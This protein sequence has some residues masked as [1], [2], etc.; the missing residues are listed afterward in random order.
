[1]V[2]DVT[3]ISKQPGAG[4]EFH[5]CQDFGSFASA[6]DQLSFEGP[7]SVDGT[8]MNIGEGIYEVQAKVDCTWVS[9]CARCLE[10]VSVPMAVELKERFVRGADE[11][12]DAYPF[13]ND[14][15]VL[16]AFV[17]DGILLDLPTQVFCRADCKGLCPVCGQN[18]NNNPQC[19]CSGAE[20]GDHRLFALAALLNSDDEE[21]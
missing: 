20:A 19:S 4:M 9:E 14:S 11:G 15:L 2:V 1:M 17:R 5:F 3:R 21:V 6:D 8:V 18:L 7:I 10:P 16:D 12:D 13:S